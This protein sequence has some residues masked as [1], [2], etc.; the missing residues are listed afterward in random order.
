M[1]RSVPCPHS[2]AAGTGTG[3]GLHIFTINYTLILRQMRDRMQTSTIYDKCDVKSHWKQYWHHKLFFIVTFLT[4]GEPG[5]KMISFEYFAP[6]P[7]LPP[8]LREAV[9]N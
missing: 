6:T 9:K 2:Q 8:T 1:Q 3:L 7:S 5:I 4:G